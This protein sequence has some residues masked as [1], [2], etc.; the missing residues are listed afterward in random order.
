MKNAV[1][2]LETKTAAERQAQIGEAELQVAQAKVAAVE[3]SR[4]ALIEQHE[5]NAAAQPCPEA[6]P[7]PPCA[8]PAEAKPKPPCTE[9]L[10]AMP[11]PT[12]AEQLQAISLGKQKATDAALKSA[13]EKLKAVKLQS[14]AQEASMKAQMV[15]VQMKQLDDA[16][17]MQ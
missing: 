6:M 13:E 17:G 10:P 9:Q 1:A 15:A 8:E 16:A 11:R 2:A 14:L 5:D 3:A 7:R 4:A 12:A